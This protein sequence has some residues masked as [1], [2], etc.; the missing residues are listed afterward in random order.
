MYLFIYYRENASD[1]NGYNAHS[2]DFGIDTISE[3]EDLVETWANFILKN[4]NYKKTWMA[5]YELHIFKDGI[6]IIENDRICEDSAE[7]PDNFIE[8]SE[9]YNHAKTKAETEHNIQKQKEYMETAQ[10]Q[11]IEFKRLQEKRRLEFE[12]LKKEFE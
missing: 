9:I 10:K 3:K 1:Y 7:N 6:Q 5:E 4:M 2:S 12:K 8:I 11:A